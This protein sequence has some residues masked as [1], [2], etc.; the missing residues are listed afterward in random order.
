MTRKAR[1]AAKI[2]R[3]IV[4]SSLGLSA[5]KFEKA[6]IESR[7][8]AR[9]T[10]TKSAKKMAALRGDKP[11]L[12]PLPLHNPVKGKGDT[13]QREVPANRVTTIRLTGSRQ[14]QYTV[15]ADYEALAKAV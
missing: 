11:K 7:N 1:L 2:A 14:A 12:P 15:E 13:P 8:L 6:R 5:D 9:N 4:R 10:S 3:R